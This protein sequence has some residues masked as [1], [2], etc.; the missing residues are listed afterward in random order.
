MSNPAPDCKQG[1][2][3]YTCQGD[4]K[5]TNKYRDQQDPD[6][7]KSKAKDKAINQLP[8]RH[9]CYGN[10][11]KLT[12]TSPPPGQRKKISGPSSSSMAPDDE[13]CGDK[14]SGKGDNRGY[15]GRDLTDAYR[16]AAT[17][18]P[19]INRG[20]RFEYEAADVDKI[21]S[22]YKREW[23]YY[24]EMEK[25]TTDC[26]KYSNPPAYNCLPSCRAGARARGSLRKRQLDN[27]FSRGMSAPCDSGWSAL[28]NFLQGYS[29]VPKK[30]FPIWVYMQEKTMEYE[31]VQEYK[32]NWTTG[33]R[34]EEDDSRPCCCNKEICDCEVF[35][36]P[37][38]ECPENQSCQP[39]DENICPLQPGETGCCKPTPCDCEVFCTATSTC[40]ENQG[41]EPVGDNCPLQ[42]GEIGC[43]RPNCENT[44]ENDGDCDV[45]GE[46]CK[47]GCCWDGDCRYGQWYPYPD[48]ICLGTIFQQTRELVEGPSTCPVKT[49]NVAGTKDCS[50]PST[51]SSLGLLDVDQLLQ[52]LKHEFIESV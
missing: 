17:D 37:T 46:T 40:P 13:C 41:C 24:D 10:Q 47:N 39:V 45:A 30:K 31:E 33:W 44:C 9:K 8:Q 48:Q 11:L 18:G 52:N 51:S 2:K 43:C 28:M 16:E 20:Y 25:N 3:S 32:T 26:C 12:T 6:I 34:C 22:M 15:M 49:Q 42:P 23:Q 36:T 5:I 19:I 7:N 21:R 38:S 29:Q 35:C 1:Y 50:G 4:L 27:L 14:N